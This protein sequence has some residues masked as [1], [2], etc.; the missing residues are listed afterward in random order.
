MRRTE[1]VNHI[2]GSYLK[3]QYLEAFL[4]QSAYIEGLLKILLDYKY[5]E[6][7]EKRGV[8]VNKINEE[9]RI[10]VRK[11]GLSELA[12]FLKKIELIDNNQKKKID[13]YRLKR[14]KVLH[15]LVL[16]ISTDDFEKELKATC[17]LGDRIT[18]DEKFKKIESILDG[19]ETHHLSS[20]F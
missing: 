20:E 11:F 18:D 17:E 9:I 4:V 1:L 10:R 3:K 2:K 16:Q 13:E 14:N 7:V 5:W 6:E 12:D 19:V 8:E 15:D